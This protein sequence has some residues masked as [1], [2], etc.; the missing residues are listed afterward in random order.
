MNTMCT[1]S[2]TKFNNNIAQNIERH[3]HTTNRLS[4]QVTIEQNKNRHQKQMNPISCQTYQHPTPMHIIQLE[5]R[6]TKH[7]LN[8]ESYCT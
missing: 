5:P 6:H 8:K 1:T 2:L 4:H 7:L 3:T